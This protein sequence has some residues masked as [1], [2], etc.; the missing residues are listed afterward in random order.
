MLTAYAKPALLVLMVFGAGLCATGLRDIARGARRRSRIG[1][2]LRSLAFV[3]A[4]GQ[5]WRPSAGGPDILVE[6]AGSGFVHLTC[7]KG[8][9]VTHWGESRERWDLRVRSAELYL[10]RDSTVRRPA[11]TARRSLHPA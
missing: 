8:K 9:A 1:K 2:H 3:P 5:V 10:L 6:F 7:R 11:R 4:A